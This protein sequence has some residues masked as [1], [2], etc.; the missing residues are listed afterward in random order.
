MPS[1]CCCTYLA[2]F[3]SS[4]LWQFPKKNNINILSHLTKTETCL[5]IW[6]NVVTIVSQSIRLLPSHMHEDVHATRQLHI[7]HVNDNGLVNAM[8]NMK[9]MLVQFTTLV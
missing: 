7:I 4:N 8:L 6:L 2:K 3:R 1:V 9:K 5:V